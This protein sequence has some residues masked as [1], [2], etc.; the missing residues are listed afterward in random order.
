MNK[1]EKQIPYPKFEKR[2]ART[3]P[4]LDE[5]DMYILRFI[6]E[7]LHKNSKIKGSELD[8]LRKTFKSTHSSLLIH[9]KRLQ[10]L[11]LIDI[12]R[13]PPQNIKKVINISP[14]GKILV[15]NLY[16]EVFK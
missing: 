12:A 14:F 6:S 8:V 7:S 10:K 11:K 16:N 1:M 9:L 4:V 5:L 15:E 13:V 3:P 2:K